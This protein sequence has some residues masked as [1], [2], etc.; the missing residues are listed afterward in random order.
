MTD[1]GLYCP[2]G[3]FHIDPWRPAGRAVITH[4][5]AD[6]ARR[7]SRHYL[8][9][10]EGEHVLRARLGQGA[11]IQ[12]L[13]YGESLTLN[14]AKVSL[15]PAGHILGSAQIRVEVNGEV[16][17]ASGDY[18]VEP[19]PT[20]SPFEPVR[21]HTFITE[22][23]FGLPIYRWPDREQIAAD[24]NRWWAANRDNGVASLLLGY[25]LGKSQRLLAKLD[26]SVG[27]IHTH[28][29][30]EKL[31]RAYRESNIAL[32]ETTPVGAMPRKHDWAGSLIV[33]PPSA[34]G[35][36]WARRFGPQ[37]TA[38]ASGWMTIRGT[39]RRKA[40]D[41]GFVVSDHADWPGLLWAIEETGA[42][43]VIATHGYTAVLTRW[44]AERA[45]RAEAV[46]THFV[47]DGDAGEDDAEE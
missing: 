45:I 35:S 1:A 39:R 2:A 47:G 40:V 27:P 42:E 13:G 24:I 14:D 8:A 25:A 19:D 32:P 41:R 46:E 23:T 6:H 9:S 30:V 7:G 5:H 18:K 17:V 16:W 10:E 21:C 36:T 38:A 20:C 31:N 4:A 22:S 12:T 11:S 44:L 43:H 3:D 29:A 33:A 37:S 34:H 26:P 28:G 15:H